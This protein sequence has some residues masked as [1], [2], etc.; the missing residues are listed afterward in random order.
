MRQIGGNTWCVD[1]I[2]QGEVIDESRDLAE[3]R[4]G[5]C[6]LIWQSNCHAL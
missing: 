1:D 3:Q 5:L 2:E 4:E 6:L